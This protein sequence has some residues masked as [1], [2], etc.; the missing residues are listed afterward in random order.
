[1]LKDNTAIANNVI[2]FPVD[3][4]VRMVPEESVIRVR[5]KNKKT[6]MTEIATA[7]IQDL[8]YELQ[9]SYEVDVDAPNFIVEYSLAVEMLAAAI[10]RT[11]G[12]PH[13][14]QSL[15]DTMLKNPDINVHERRKKKSKKSKE[16]EDDED[17][18]TI[19][20]EPEFTLD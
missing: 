2:N 3:K 14:L 13:P 12:V 7:V 5:E 16:K 17:K 6:R 4:V 9:N 10:F 15:M 8:F 20:F 18:D 19:E 11:E 1:M